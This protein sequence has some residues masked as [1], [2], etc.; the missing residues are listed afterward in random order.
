MKWSL[1]LP[2]SQNN[3]QG[4]IPMLLTV[5]GFRLANNLSLWI[6]F[7]FIEWTKSINSLSKWVRKDYRWSS[8]QRTSHLVYMKSL[9]LIVNLIIT[10]VYPM[11]G[12]FH[13]FSIDQ[14]EDDDLAG[15]IPVCHGWGYSLPN[16]PSLTFQ[17][18]IRDRLQ[19]KTGQQTLAFYRH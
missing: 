15:N 9:Y 12:S 13:C 14:T 10:F 7:Y 4:F 11:L 8:N 18:S 16:H 5:P 2:I 6:K 1:R 3:F 17:W 19:L